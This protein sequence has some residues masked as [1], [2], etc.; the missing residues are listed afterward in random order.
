MDGLQRILNFL[1]KLGDKD[2]EF[3]INQYSPDQLTVTFG[4]VGH[5]IEVS[6][7]VDGMDYSVFTGSEAVSTDEAGLFDLIDKQSQ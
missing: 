3:S 6:F 1:S 5:R 4:L 7:D 2:I